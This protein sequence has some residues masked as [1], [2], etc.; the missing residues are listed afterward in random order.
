[1]DRSHQK[2]LSGNGGESHIHV[3]T[4]KIIVAM[5]KLHKTT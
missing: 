2:K 3:Q 1:M 5:T 4:K